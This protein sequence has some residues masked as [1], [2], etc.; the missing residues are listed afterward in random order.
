[1]AMLFAIKFCN[2][3]CGRLGVNR[4]I[5]DFL[6]RL[7]LHSRGFVVPSTLDEWM[8]AIRS[9]TE[10]QLNDFELAWGETPQ[11]GIS[12]RALQDAVRRIHSDSVYL[13]PEFIP[14]LVE[15][16]SVRTS[17]NSMGINLLQAA[18]EFTGSRDEDLGYHVT[19]GGQDQCGVDSNVKIWLYDRSPDG[20]GSCRTIRNWFEIPRFVREIIEESDSQRR[21]LPSNDFI[22]VLERYLHPCDAHMAGATAYACDVRDINPETINYPSL[23]RDIQFDYE[24]YREDWKRIRDDYGFDHSTHIFL[25]LV[26]NLLNSDST[27]SER[28][29]K[30]AAG[31]HSSCVQCLQEWGISMLGPLDGPMYAN[32]RLTEQIVR[33]AMISMPDDFRR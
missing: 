11:G 8:D 1:M 19:I 23:N 26:Y 33:S 20:N 14:D 30:A 32:K 15:D 25:D 21:N 18:R 2:I 3:F 16:W 7:V 27:V 4:F 17:C 29:K 12:L 28:T 22:E 9:I 5:A 31:C 13:D 24:N 10:Q 6:L